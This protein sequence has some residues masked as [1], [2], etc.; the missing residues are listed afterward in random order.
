MA[1]AEAWPELSIIQ[2]VL[3]QIPWYHNIDL[4]DKLKHLEERLWHVQK[5]IENGLDL[6]RSRHAN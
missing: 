1:F 2:E 3:G 6:Q 4:L 5:P